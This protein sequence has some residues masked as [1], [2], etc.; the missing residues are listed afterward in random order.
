MKI[1]EQNVGFIGAGN[2]AQA[3]GFSFIESGIFFFVVVAQHIVF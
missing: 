1:E 2:M 3:I